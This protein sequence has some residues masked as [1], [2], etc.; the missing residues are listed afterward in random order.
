MMASVWSA[1]HRRKHNTNSWK[2][3]SLAFFSRAVLQFFSAQLMLQALVGGT[4]DAYEDIGASPVVHGECHVSP[5]RSALA[6][7]MIDTHDFCLG[8]NLH[9]CGG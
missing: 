5:K 3:I 8:I 4:M 1:P 9:L 7:T 2:G 6:A